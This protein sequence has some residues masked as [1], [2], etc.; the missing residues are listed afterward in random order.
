[1]G[2]GIR[3][4][5]C[6][7]KN[8]LASAPGVPSLEDLNRKPLAVI[9]CIEPIPC[10]PCEHACPFQAITVGDPIT[11]CPVLD[12]EKCTGCGTCIACCPGLAIFVIDMNFTAATALVTIPYELYPL[13][14]EGAE[15]DCLDRGGNT[16]AKG[17]I[18]TVKTSEKFDKTSLVSIELS[19]EFAM[20]VRNIRMC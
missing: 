1:M 17:R 3:F 16:V 20:D 19:K 8:E 2:T 15:I 13:P 9:E 11:N 18:H 7:S 12:P 6:P 10:N 5:G 14:Q 4:N